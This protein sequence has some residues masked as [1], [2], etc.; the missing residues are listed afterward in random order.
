MTD[1]T[2]PE[3]G[4]D[5]TND[6][7]SG[8]GMRAL[9][10]AHLGQQF[11][12]DRDLY[13]SFG[14]I[15]DPDISHYYGN[16]LRHPYARTVVD[17]PVQATWRD[18]PNI[19][20]E[21]DSE[22][23]EQTDFES[24]V[25]EIVDENRV[26]HYAKRADKLAGIGEYGLLVIGFADGKDLVRKVDERQLSGPEDIDWLRPFSQKS[27][28]SLRLGDE[29][30]ARWGKPTYYKLDLGDEDD[31]TTTA[32]TE[33]YVHHSRV[34]HIAENLLDD[35]VRGTPR[36]EP[37]LNVLMDIEKTLG[38]AA[39][40]AYRGAR[41][42]LHIN[43]DDQYS[44]NDDGTKLRQEA[45]DFIHG[46]QPFMVT[47]HADV[48]DIG[49][50]E[51]DPSNIIDSE[52]EALSAYTGIP[53]SVL[54][55]NE[56]GERATSQDLKEWYGKISERRNQYATPVIVRDLI[57][58]FIQYGVVSPPAGDGY[59][60]DWPALAEQSEMDASEVM[61]NRAQVIKFVKSMLAGYG[62][63]DVAEFIETGE[64]PDLGGPSEG[65]AGVPDLDESNEEVQEHFEQAF[66]NAVAGADD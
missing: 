37:V 50:G 14:W 24:D 60:T 48:E 28:E 9:L 22:A 4:L 54:K 59:T 19:V 56:T 53:Q 15:K 44:L 6:D 12:G 18:P 5:R 52:I 62:T 38:S 45:K 66:D 40:I 61:V 8:V 30:S 34:V 16:Y 7:F 27:V 49:G 39:E 29:D 3:D 2:A 33:T 51:L 26:W 41:D 47:E 1:H 58:R 65:T 32:S 10:A 23:G 36:Q 43:V 21:Q 46:L 20:D 25:E 42:S 13:D 63:E 57:D 17:A 31:D 11:G 55:G 35:E 64:F